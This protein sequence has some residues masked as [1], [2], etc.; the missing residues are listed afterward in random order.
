MENLILIVISALLMGLSFYLVLD[1]HRWISMYRV[2]LHEADCL[3]LT[4][5]ELDAKCI[6]FLGKK[7]LAEQKMRLMEMKAEAY[8]LPDG[9]FGTEIDLLNP[10]I[11]EIKNAE[12]P[13]I[14]AKFNAANESIDG[15]VSD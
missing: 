10:V 1:R 13:L 4:I 7:D 14:N 11:D 8:K 15:R 9:S 12:A 2:T 5:K 3:R 6:L